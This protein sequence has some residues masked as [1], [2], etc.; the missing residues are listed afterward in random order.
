MSAPALRVVITARDTRGHVAT[1][2]ARFAILGAR[3]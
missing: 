1:T 2:N 3:P